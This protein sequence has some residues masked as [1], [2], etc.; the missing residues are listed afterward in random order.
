MIDLQKRRQINLLSTKISVA[1]KKLDRTGI[2]ALKHADG[3]M[4]D[5]EYAVT[6][7]ERALVYS[8]IEALEAELKELEDSENDNNN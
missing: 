8:E 2:M 7:G 3:L 1:K 5:D 4:T 6:K